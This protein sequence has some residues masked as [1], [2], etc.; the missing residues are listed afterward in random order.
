MVQ[1][2]VITVVIAVVTGIAAAAQVSIVRAENEYHVRSL[3]QTIASLP[4]VVDGLQ[5]PDP[6]ATIQPVMA[7]LQ[8][9]S[10]VDFIAVVDMNNLRVSHPDPAMIGLPPSTDHEDVRHGEEFVGVEDGTL[11]PT[12]R[13]KLPVRAADGTII[14]TVSVG[15]VE[16]RLTND[17]IQRTWQLIG[18]AAGALILGSVLSWFVTRSIRRRLYGVDP[19]E[20]RTLLQTRESMLAGVSDGFVAVDDRGRIALANAAAEHLLG[21][22]DLVGR[23]ASAV[24]PSPLVTLIGTPPDDTATP[25]GGERHP[26][27]GRLVRAVRT[28]DGSPDEP[29]APTEPDRSQLELA[30]RSLVVTRSEAHVHG[31]RVGTTLLFQN[32]TELEHALAQLDA[33]T[34]RANAMRRETHEFENRLHAIGGL[35]SLGEFD[36]ASRLLERSPSNGR[37]GAR[38]GLDRVAPPL[39]AAF[40]DAR[41]SAAEATGIRVELTDDSLVDAE[42]P[43]D[44]DTITIIGNLLGNAVEA[45][46]SRVEVY[47]RGDADGLEGRIEDDGPG[48]PLVLRDAVFE[49][50]IS[51]KPDSGPGRGVGLHLVATLLAEHGGSV[52][53]DDSALGG[54]AFDVWLPAGDAHPHP[55]ANEQERDA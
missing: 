9:A 50:G 39:L 21:R 26:V 37:P 48:V 3:A 10:G 2:A 44:P 12:F 16:T 8:Q 29:A 14:G 42:C 15:I 52:Q 23:P 19:D 49:E 46:T 51:T 27:T 17:V 1:I 30:G 38:S 55:D 6:A 24:L 7:A 41:T 34:A 28:P 36:E 53:I 35:L 4:T 13:V 25:D 31:T 47:L 22:G 11:G 45:A 43:C 54:A 5:S 33:Q 32:R 18:V 20:L 40:L